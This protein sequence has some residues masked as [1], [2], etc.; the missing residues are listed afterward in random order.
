MGQYVGELF[1]TWD[2]FVNGILCECHVE[3][4]NMTASCFIDMMQSEH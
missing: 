4:E 1:C 3:P 2:P